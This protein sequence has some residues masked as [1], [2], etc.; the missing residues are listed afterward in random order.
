M[1]KE[2]QL[3]TELYH[4]RYA[5][6]RYTVNHLKSSGNPHQTANFV[7]KSINFVPKEFSFKE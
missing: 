7:S 4:Q 5:I 2:K 6:D 3:E 1:Q